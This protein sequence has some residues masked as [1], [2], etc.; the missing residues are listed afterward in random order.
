MDAALEVVCGGSQEGRKVEEDG[1]SE[2]D[3]HLASSAIQVGGVTKAGGIG[4]GQVLFACGCCSSS[5][6]GEYGIV[7]G[8]EDSDMVRID[9]CLELLLGSA[10]GVEG[11]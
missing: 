1:P 3:L 8:N 4:F 10:C 9:E 11:Y 2:C 5:C 6:V 7:D